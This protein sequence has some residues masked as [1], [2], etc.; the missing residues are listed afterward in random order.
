MLH[1]LPLFLNLQ[2]GEKVR[3]EIHILRQFQHPHVI[4]LYEVL[5]TPTDIYS[6]ME[7]IPG[8]ELFDYIV[9]RGRLEEKEA[10]RIFQQ[11]ISGVEYCHVHMVVHR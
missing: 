6:V 1:C 10:R 5:E 7:Y 11:I 4:R 9:S 3:T 8:G 2:M